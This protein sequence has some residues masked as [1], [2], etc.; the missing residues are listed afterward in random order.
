[1]ENVQKTYTDFHKANTSKHVYP[2]EWVIRTLLG[3]YPNL[4]LDKSKYPGAKILDLGFGDCRNMPLLSNCN[5]D[6]YG[7]E[8]SEGILQLAEHTLDELGITATLKIGTNTSIPFA[9]N[10]FDYMLACY[11]CYYVDQGTTFRDNLKEMARV[12]KPGATLIASL[13]GPGN[14]IRKD[15][16]KL[17]DGH[18]MITKDI[19]GLRNGYVFKTFD[20]EEDV[21]ETFSP[22]FDNISVCFSQDDFWGLQLNNFFIACCKI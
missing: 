6:I 15:S 17:E 19:F 1:M 12:L 22:L 14:F 13:I 4:D 18:E 11:S 3:K 21:R 7:L 8:I 9:D 5:F 2:T 10:Y 16:K 20:S